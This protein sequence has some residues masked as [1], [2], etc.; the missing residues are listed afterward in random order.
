MKDYMPHRS[1][2]DELYNDRKK[3]EKEN[4]PNLNQ[5]KDKPVSSQVLFDQNTN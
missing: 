3:A 4:I 5:K 2:C 1:R